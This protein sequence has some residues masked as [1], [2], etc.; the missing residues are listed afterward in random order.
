MRKYIFTLVV[1]SITAIVIFYFNIAGGR[2]ENPSYF[3]A[4]EENQI[5]GF[6]TDGNE[7]NSYISSSP[8]SPRSGGW[9]LQTMPNMGNRLVRDLYFTD[10]LTGYAVASPDS[11]IDSAHILKT[12]DGGTVWQKILTKN[13]RLKRIVFINPNTGFAG[14]SYLLKTTNAGGNWNVWN[15]PLD[16]IIYDMQVFSEDTIWY[17]DTDPIAGGLFR[18]TNGGINWEKRDSGIPANSYPDNIYFYNSRIGF[19]Y[20]IGNPYSYRTT[21]G[22]LTWNVT[23][24]VFTDI[25]FKDSLSGWRA[26]SGMFRTNDGG[27]NWTKD[28]LPKVLGNIYT[29]N[30]STNFIRTN[31]STLY[32]YGSYLYYYANGRYAAIIYKTTNGGINWG[33]QIPDTN[34]TLF[35]LKYGYSL[36]RNNVW[37]YNESNKGIYT[38]V[39]GDTTIYLDVNSISSVIPASIY[40]LQNYPNPFNPLTKI[41]FG[42]SKSGSINFKIYDIS[43]KTIK[44]I[45]KNSFYLAGEYEYTFD[46]T[47]L[48][49]G[50]YFYQLT[51]NSHGREQ[52]AIKKMVM[53]K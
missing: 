7:F 38:S 17:G 5:K 4:A 22:G 19:A 9:Q 18:T 24:F 16:R 29:Y 3:K 36:N 8:Y 15:W 11:P 50:V 41:R 25:N 51:I 23:N 12:T 42:L 40:L 30:I 53:I 34:Y 52:L 37:L 35:R 20:K 14:G 10:S 21:D 48:S 13:G 6:G 32:A 26:Q 39:G 33:Y 28:S 27:L 44:E 31:D 1:T 46:G 43:G 45:I 2:E 47:S 49:S